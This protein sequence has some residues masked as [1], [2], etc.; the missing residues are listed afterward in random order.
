MMDILFT[1]LLLWKKK[2]FSMLVWLLLPVIGT[3]FFITT[4]T[5]IEEDSRVPIG[6]VIEDESELA[7]QLIDSL[8]ASKLVQVSRYSVEEGIYDL[9][10]HEIDSIFVIHDGFEKAI[11]SGKR[12]NLISSYRTELSFAYS[13]VKELIVSLVQEESGR[14]KATQFILTMNEEYKGEGS[15]TWDEITEKS[16]EIQID[17]NLLNTSFSYSNTNEFV[18]TPSLLSGETWGVWAIFSLLSALFLTDWVI[19]EKSL[20]VTTRFSFIKVTQ[21]SYYLNNILCYLLLFLLFDLVSVAAFTIYLNEPL[22]MR[23]IFVLLTFRIMLC[24]LTFCLAQCFSKTGVFYG[25]SIIT[26]LILAVISGTIIPILPQNGLIELL[27]PLQAFLNGNITI[28]WNIIGI[29]TLTMVLFRKETTN[30]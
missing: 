14:A 9:E 26:T 23:F 25:F 4:V 12:N 19:R 20:A 10:K 11:L 8:V 3:S 21:F 7:T 18:E 27:N 22:S 5:T 17:E 30:A 16:K 13:P 1:R 24:S 28:L 2:A 15:L 29:S 6:I